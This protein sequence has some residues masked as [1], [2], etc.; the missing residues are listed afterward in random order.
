M[1]TGIN[2]SF[3]QKKAG[4]TLP[5]MGSTY[6]TKSTAKNIVAEAVEKKQPGTYYSST[7]KTALVITETGKTYTVHSDDSDISVKKGEHIA[8]T[9]PSKDTLYIQNDKLGFLIKEVWDIDTKYTGKKPTIIMVANL[10]QII[11][12]HKPK[13][14]KPLKTKVQ[15]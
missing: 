10:P 13:Q 2:N 6:P 4:T 7:N 15:N 11:A 1:L 3:S 8:F 14:V 9:T 5:T 12:A